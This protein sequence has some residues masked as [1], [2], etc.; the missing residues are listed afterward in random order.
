MGQ[1]PAHNWL[2]I[3]RFA[4]SP[5]V[6][7]RV[8]KLRK[9][10]R[11]RKRKKQRNRER[12]KETE[13]ETRWWWQ[14]DMTNCSKSAKK[15]VA[16]LVFAL[17][18]DDDLI[19]RNSIAMC[20]ICILCRRGANCCCH[21]EAESRGVGCK[22]GIY[23][24]QKALKM[25]T[26]A[27]PQRERERERDDWGCQIMHLD[28]V[29]ELFL[30]TCNN[31]NNFSTTILQNSDFLHACTSHPSIWATCCTYTLHSLS[32]AALLLSAI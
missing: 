10:E 12:Q 16:R 31:T 22:R 19:A 29:H 13:R 32:L 17:P 3:V 23:N 11:Q 18:L 28:I 7:E 24:Y 5:A 20:W 6:S 2:L 1:F 25:A 14:R 26:A 21:A 9:G 8:R 30:T 27:A 15:R 4:P